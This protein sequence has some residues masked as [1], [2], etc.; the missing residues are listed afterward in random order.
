MMETKE[1]TLKAVTD[2]TVWMLFVTTTLA[3]VVL[4]AT[5][6][7]HILIGSS[8]TGLYHYGGSI[9]SLGLH[10]AVRKL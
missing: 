9:L 1:T 6:T 4:I 2:F 3:T 7:Y 8:M 5:G 10:Y